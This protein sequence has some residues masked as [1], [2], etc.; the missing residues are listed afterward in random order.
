M[1]QRQLLTETA[2]YGG[3]AVARHAVGFFLIPYYTRVLDQASFGGLDLILAGTGLVAL[4]LDLQ[5]GAS[6]TRYFHFAGTG[7]EEKARYVGGM[8]VFRAVTAALPALLLGAAFTFLG[9]GGVPLGKEGRLAIVLSLLG[10]PFSLLMEYQ[11]LLFRLMEWRWRYAMLSLGGAVV[12]GSAVILCVTVFGMGIAGVILGQTMASAALSLV[13]LAFLH[14]E[15]RFQWR[16]PHLGEHLR[17]GLPLVPGLLLGWCW[18]YMNRF[19]LAMRLPL[20]EIAVF[21][22][23]MKVLV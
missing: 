12:G 4:I 13:Q 10:V 1:G 14:G 2:I 6:T 20:N 17:Y 18:V 16:P 21:A 5:L 22:L 9:G 15:L 7:Q 3:T 11:F 19:L 23:A 8:I